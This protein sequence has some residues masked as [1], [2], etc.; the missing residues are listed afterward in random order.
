MIHIPQTKDLTG[1]VFGKL[2]VISRES[3]NKD[4]RSMWLCKCSCGKD[5]IISGKSLVSGHTRSCGCL[6]LDV[7]ADKFVKCL[8]GQKFGRLTVEK[9]ADDYISPKGKHHVRW[10]CKCACGNSTIVDACQLTSGKTKS[11]G[12]LQKE[13]LSAGNVVHGGRYDRLYHVWSNIKNRCYNEN[14]SD[15]IYYGGRGVCMCE[16]WFLD[17]RSFKEWAINAGYDK[18]AE[19]GKCTIDRIDVN[20]NYEPNNCRWVDMKI[21]SNNRRNVKFT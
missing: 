10:L 8:C 12:C 14:S 21:Q 7:A 13:K 18:N 9:R 20:G 17:Y 11:C 3:N 15:Y 2:T 16:E 6:R 1:M 19:F 4:G 5:K